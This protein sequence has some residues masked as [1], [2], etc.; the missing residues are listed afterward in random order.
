MPWSKA[1]I[2]F[3]PGAILRDTRQNVLFEALETEVEEKECNR[4]H[5]D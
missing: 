2:V 5:L 1:R 3:S 4:T